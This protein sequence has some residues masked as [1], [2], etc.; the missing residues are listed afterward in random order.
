MGLLGRGQLL[1]A[2]VPLSLGNVAVLARE[3]P[4]RGGEVPEEGGKT[5]LLLRCR[6]LPTLLVFEG[7][8][9]GRGAELGLSLGPPL[10]VLER[11]LSNLSTKLGLGLG[12]PLLFFES[13]LSN[14]GPELGL[15]L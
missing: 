13:L 10:L 2:Q 15:G 7:L 14:L 9:S 4:F 3:V 5:L 12:T 11:L 1:S 8:L 6:L